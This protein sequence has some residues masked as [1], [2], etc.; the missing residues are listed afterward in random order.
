[1]ISCNFWPVVKKKLG[2]L[3]WET[4]CLTPSRGLHLSDSVFLF[5]FFA[6][7]LLVWVIPSPGFPLSLPPV[8]LNQSH[9]SGFSRQQAACPGTKF[10]ENSVFSH[11]SK[12]VTILCLCR[13]GRMVSQATS[14]LISDR[15]LAKGCQGQWCVCECPALPGSWGFMCLLSSLW[16]SCSFLFPASVY[17]PCHTN[18]TSY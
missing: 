8:R 13:K 7:V 4:I 2:S 17:Y 15:P 1:M 9:M 10:N 14:C 12:P 18:E 6:L 3:P 16:M 5:F 11:P